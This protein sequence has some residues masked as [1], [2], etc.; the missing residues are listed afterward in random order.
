MNKNNNIKKQST[1]L[2]RVMGKNFPKLYTWS[3]TDT[4]NMRYG[5]S[6][7]YVIDNKLKNHFE[8]KLSQN[9]VFITTILVYFEKKGTESTGI[10]R[11]IHSNET[12]TISIQTQNDLVKLVVTKTVN[13]RK[14][15][16][17]VISK[18]T[19][20][21]CFLGSSSRVKYTLFENPHHYMS[22]M[23]KTDTETVIKMM[24]DP[25]M[26]RLHF[27]DGVPDPNSDENIDDIMR[28]LDVVRE[29]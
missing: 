13:T 28:G 26:E 22:T 25:V 5:N 20:F 16:N 18:G 17:P 4:G 21:S 7:H 29:I 24:S 9:K 11:V 6:G 27:L 10:V 12:D 23:T 1:F 14:E 19:L 2:G 3:I 15:V 8:Q